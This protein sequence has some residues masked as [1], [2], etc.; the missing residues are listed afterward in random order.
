MSEDNKSGD[1]QSDQ[2][3]MVPN[4][5]GPQDA[6]D[7]SSPGMFECIALSLHADATKA[8]EFL[9]WPDGRVLTMT[10]YVAEAFMPSIPNKT[11]ADSLEMMLR[12]SR[13]N[14]NSKETF[15][16]CLALKP[17]FL[18][19][20]LPEGERTVEKILETY[21]RDSGLWGGITLPLPAAK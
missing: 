7:Q 19:V 15:P 9:T 17:E 20:L 1:R 11:S 5:L 12:N 18:K 14:R 16:V 8:G 13:A 6:V 3:P 10:L 4:S 2:T 21:P